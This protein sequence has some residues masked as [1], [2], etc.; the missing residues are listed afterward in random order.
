MWKS[1]QRVF[2]NNI[3]MKTI[4]WVLEKVKLTKLVNKLVYIEQ[5]WPISEV[6]KFKGKIAKKLEIL[7][8]NKVNGYKGMPGNILVYR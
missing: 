8:S 1:R 6:W 2:V 7:I 3:P 4:K 5:K